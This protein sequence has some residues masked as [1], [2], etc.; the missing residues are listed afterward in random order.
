MSYWL[1]EHT[2][3]HAVN[4]G[5][6][7]FWGWKTRRKSV[8]IISIHT[9]ESAFDLI[10]EDTGA[11]RVAN[12]LARWVDRPASY[13]RISDADSRE[14]L[15]PFSHTAFGARGYNA[16]AI[17]LAVAGRAADWGKLTVAQ[18]RARI[19]LLALDVADACEKYAILPRRLS[20]SAAQ[21]RGR[22][23][24]AHADLD[25]DRRSD[26]GRL[27]PWEQ[28][29]AATV[30]ELD[31]RQEPDMPEWLTRWPA[32]FRDWAKSARSRHLI[33]EYTDP[34]EKVGDMPLGEFLVLR[35]RQA[36]DIVRRIRNG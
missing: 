1:L 22:G 13:H 23:L 25:P 36:D 7:G 6:P 24:C 29:I 11:D 28:L 18:R 34:N 31:N 10:G 21:G 17:H 26:P 30:R 2:N 8:R 32:A 19:D 3:Q 33:T 12:Y 15:L 20:S 27:F 4:A 14:R 35:D 9:T 16:D 5:Y